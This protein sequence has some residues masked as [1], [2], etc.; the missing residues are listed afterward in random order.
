MTA[1][2]FADSSIMTPGNHGH[3][4]QGNIVAD[5]A[6]GRAR[7]N[8]VVWRT[9]LCLSVLLIFDKNLPLMLSDCHRSLTKS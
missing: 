4:D 7:S 5:S 8:E 3:F 2:S 9:T 6:S 1:D